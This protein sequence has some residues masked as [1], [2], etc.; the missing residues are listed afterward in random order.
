M[1]HINKKREN[2]RFEIIKL[3]SKLYIC[4]GFKNTSF[5]KIA[6]ILDLSTGNITFYFPSKEHL[7]AVLVDELCEF[8]KLLME[9]ATNEGKKSLLAYCL[10]LTSMAAAC[11]EDDAARD[12]FLTAYTSPM[13]FELIRK[14]DTEKTKNVF[15]EFNPD[16]T[17]EQWMIM[18][19]LVSGMEYSVLAT[20]E[21]NTPLPVQIE[22]TLESIMILYNVPEEIRKTKIKKV[23]SM[24]YKAFGRRILKEF[25]EYIEK[26]D[27][28]QEIQPYL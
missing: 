8:Q 9:Q 2:T 7:L 3:A 13:T 14:N 17:D 23:F 28:R 10:E 5:S 18:E 25:K 11:E 15:G 12:F 24:D 6:K 19:N 1:P 21:K 22:K 27:E 26:I 20:R 4:E 16:W